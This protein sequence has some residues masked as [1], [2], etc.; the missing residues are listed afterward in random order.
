MKGFYTAEQLRSPAE[1]TPGVR[2]V[3]LRHAAVCMP[4]GL[5]DASDVADALGKLLRS[6]GPQRARVSG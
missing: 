4:K 2:L 5:C 3:I 6:F 1:I